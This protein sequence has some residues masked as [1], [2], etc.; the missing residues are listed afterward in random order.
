M[1]ELAKL[2]IYE[3][4]QMAWAA[5]FYMTG[6]ATISRHG[7]PLEED[8]IKSGKFRVKFSSSMMGTI[9]NIN[10][11][12]RAEAQA[13]SGAYLMMARDLA[14]RVSR[15][16]TVTAM[17]TF[18][19]YEIEATGAAYD[20][21][22]D[23]CKVYAQGP[24]ILVMKTAD[25]RYRV[26]ANTNRR[27]YKDNPAE[28]QKALLQF[29]EMVKLHADAAYFYDIEKENLTLG[30]DTAG[31]RVE[32][33]A[34]GDQAQLSTAAPKAERALDMIASMQ[35]KSQERVR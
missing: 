22:E 35:A 3:Q 18:D 25:G 21:F 11:N 4:K 13:G 31:V 28:G 19:G 8:S 15:D 23:R 27:D 20:L 33:E 34:G 24:K 6:G 12:T 5:L 29:V 9:E 1:A 17:P 7:Q 2:N 32:I 26:Q 10:P 30:H 16:V 14:N